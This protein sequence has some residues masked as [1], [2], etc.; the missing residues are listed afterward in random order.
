MAQ[1]ASQGTE[2]DAAG[3]AAIHDEEAFDPEEEPVGTLAI[4][5]VYLIVIIGLWLAVYVTLIERS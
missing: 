4:L 2:R 1:P 3:H 5:T